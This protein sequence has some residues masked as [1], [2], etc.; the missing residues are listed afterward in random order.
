MSGSLGSPQAG[1]GATMSYHTD[2]T[3]PISSTEQLKSPS[4]QS[5]VSTTPINE[6]QSS[7]NR[8]LQSLLIA[9]QSK[10][11]G[12][13]TYSPRGTST[14]SP[15]EP[16][17]SS[18]LRIISSAMA[19]AP[20][21]PERHT[22]DPGVIPRRSSDQPVDIVRP[23]TGRLGNDYD[24]NSG[25]NPHIKKRFLQARDR[26]Q[27]RKSMAAMVSNRFK[28]FR[29]DSSQGSSHLQDTSRGSSQRGSSLDSRSPH[30]PERGRPGSSGGHSSHI[31][32]F[33]RAPT[34]SEKGNAVIINDSLNKSDDALVRPSGSLP[35]YIKPTASEE[36]GERLPKDVFDR[37]KNMIESS[38]DEAHDTSS[39]DD[40]TLEGQR[41]R[42]K[43]KK[44][45]DI[46][47]ITKSDFETPK[48][49]KPTQPEERMLLLP[50]PHL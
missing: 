31:E 26:S 47:S 19:S 8:A 17:V 15:V 14:R 6:R 42:S 11:A 32:T 2:R 18:P 27:G 25:E 12:G 28:S 10:G 21:S 37:D 49:N 20:S 38:E 46:T 35:A 36:G 24:A 13:T 33:K 4:G 9:P 45:S 39:D 23:T 43:K 50:D 7:L 3:S 16:L 29:R 1:G 34:S 5:T 41:G 40:S 48:D 22:A 30:S 44:G